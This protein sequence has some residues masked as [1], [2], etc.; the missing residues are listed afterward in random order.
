APR[1]G[2]ARRCTRR[3]PRRGARGRAPRARR[4]RAGGGLLRACGAP[5]PR[6]GPGGAMS[7]RHVRTALAAW[8]ARAALAAWL[9]ACA[10]PT[11]AEPPEPPPEAGDGDYTLEAADSLADQE[12]EV[13]VG[14]ASGASGDVRRS[15]RVSFRGGGPRRTLRGG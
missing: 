4:D 9:A 7:R 1:C 10:G 12:L 3:C 8:L 2:G 11:R 15:Q 6:T 5:G 13:A 14:A